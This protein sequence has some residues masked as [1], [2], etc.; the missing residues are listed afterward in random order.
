MAACKVIAVCATP[1]T[2]ASDRY[3]RLKQTYA[4]NITVLEPDCQT[5]ARMIEDNAMNE[6]LLEGQINA[7]LDQYADVIVL[8][9]THY[10]WI[11][12]DI[13]RLTNNRAAVIDP[14]D[15]IA[16]RVRELLG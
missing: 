8:G 2:L 3:H 5:W 14:S 9:C 12:D 13:V 7:L 11:K 15:A 6:Q 16:S 10:H 4:A 1:A